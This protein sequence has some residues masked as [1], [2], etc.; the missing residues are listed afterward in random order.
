MTRATLLLFGVERCVGSPNREGLEYTAGWRLGPRLDARGMTRSECDSS[1]GF[2]AAARGLD[3]CS[4]VRPVRYGDCR[5]D[6]GD[7]G[8]LFGLEHERPLTARGSAENGALDVEFDRANSL[9]RCGALH[10]G[11]NV[12]ARPETSDECAGIA[13][14]MTVF[15]HG[16][17][18]GGV[19]VSQSM[20]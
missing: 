11:K 18:R 4:S 19:I 16:S 20:R 7:G 3:P 5:H 12:E 10:L 13:V 6:V 8:V 9:A 17:R 2:V 1:C 14:G 15:A